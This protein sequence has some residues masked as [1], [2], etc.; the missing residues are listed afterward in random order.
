MSYKVAGFTITTNPIKEQYPIKECIMSWLSVLDELVIVDGGS[1]DGFVEWIKELNN[2][3]IILYKEDDVKWEKDWTYWRMGYNWGKGFDICDERGA[4]FI[5]KFDADYVYGGNYPLREKDFNSAVKQK[6]MIVKF[7]RKNFQMVDKYFEKTA[8]TFAVN[9]IVV[10]EKKL[11]VKWGYDL[12]NW[13]MCD[14]AI[15]Y[16][17]TKDKLKQ[18]LLLAKKSVRFFSDVPIFNYAYCFRDLE[19]AKDLMFRNMVAF[20]RQQGFRLR[21]KEQYWIR[22]IRACNNAFNSSQ[23]KPIGLAGHP[24]VMQEKIKNLAE[25]KQGYNFYG[26]KARAKYFIK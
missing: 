9:M 12:E 19:T 4:D 21:N 2:P 25:D 16:E 22:Y 18:G 1:T 7:H 6:A 8:K 5:I 14:E 26:M 20:E 13:G 3:K 23:Q 17:K 10:R 24:K 15:I 11:N